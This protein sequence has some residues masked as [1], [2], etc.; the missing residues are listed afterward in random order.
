[1][2]APYPLRSA[3]ARRTRCRLQERCSQAAPTLGLRLIPCPNAFAVWSLAHI[4]HFLFDLDG[5]L[6][7]GE[8]WL[9]GTPQLL[10]RPQATGRG[11][12]NMT[13]TSSLGTHDVVSKVERLGIGVPDG[14]QITSGGAALALSLPCRS[15]PGLRRPVRSAN[16]GCRYRADR[17]RQAPCRDSG[18]RT[19]PARGAARGNSHRRRPPLHRHR[20]VITGRIGDDP[21]AHREARTSSPNATTA[22]RTTSWIRCVS[23]QDCWT[24]PASGER[25][26]AA[27]PDLA[28]RCV[29]W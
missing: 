26:F 10:Q 3:F 13:N 15:H 20:D 25:G 6:N 9:D 22:S 24:R 23:S 4:R 18:N 16:G 19:A 17:G 29:Y 11:Y 5:T 14:H 2:H 7:P 28:Y 12:A 21:R 1:M 8:A 27:F